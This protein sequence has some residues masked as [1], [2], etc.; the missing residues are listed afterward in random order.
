MA[1]EYAALPRGRALILVMEQDPHFTKLE[2]YFLEEA[3]FEVEFASDGIQGLEK[4]RTLLP[5]IILTE[6]LLPR[7]DGLNVCR[8]IKTDP[9]T[10][11]IP[12][13]VISILAADQR[14]QEAGADACLRKP[15]ND[16]MLL[17]SVTDL[18][19]RRMNGDAH[20]AN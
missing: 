17:Q 12:V 19:A 16:A 18:L 5:D 10:R 3:G 2:R 13:L 7:M 20:G 4:A 6:I 8:A 9:R 14:A 11:H 1:S 15:L